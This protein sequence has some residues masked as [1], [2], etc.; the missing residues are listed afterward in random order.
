MQLLSLS[1]ILLALGAQ[2]VPTKEGHGHKG[3]IIDKPNN[4]NE[5]V[6]TYALGVRISPSSRSYHTFP[7]FPANYLSTEQQCTSFEGQ[8]LVN[9]RRQ[10]CQI[11]TVRQSRLPF[12]LLRSH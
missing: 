11:G 9:G 7:A 5:T 8:C 3:K 2:A 1:V 6:S 12:H 10:I 4:G